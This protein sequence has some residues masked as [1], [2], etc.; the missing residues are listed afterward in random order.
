[1]VRGVGVDGLQRQTWSPWR[2]LTVPDEPE[3]TTVTPKEKLP[4]ARRRA[5]DD[6]GVGCQAESRRKLS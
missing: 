6:P 1:M 4:P 5:G 3:S 2:S